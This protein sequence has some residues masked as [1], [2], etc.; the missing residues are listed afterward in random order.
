MYQRASWTVFRVLIAPGNDV[1]QPDEGGRRLGL[2]GRFRRAVRRLKRQVA[3]CPSASF[4]Q[5]MS[6]AD[7]RMVAVCLASQRPRFAVMGTL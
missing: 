2:V 4:W 7:P 6:N 3:M 5:T 1:E